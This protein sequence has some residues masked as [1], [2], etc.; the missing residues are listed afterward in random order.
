MK[1]AKLA[2]KLFWKIN[3]SK[4][5]SSFF[6]HPI[7]PKLCEYGVL[8]LNTRELVFHGFLMRRNLKERAIATGIF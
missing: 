5:A 6:S 1:Y 2:I 3:A 4:Q 7:D 8:G